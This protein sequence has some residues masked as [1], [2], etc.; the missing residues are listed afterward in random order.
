MAE[1][2][3][4]FITGGGSGIGRAIAQHFSGR[5]WFVG[6]GDVNGAGMAGTAELLPDG[7]CSCHLLDVR[8]AAQWEAALA[9]FAK[10]AGGAIHV[11]ANNAGVGHA[12]AI[13]ELSAA[14]VDALIDVNFRGVVHGARAAHPWL[15]ASAPESCLL[16]LASASAIYGV[17]GMSIYSATKFAVRSITEALDVEW[18]EDGIKV[19]SLMPSFIDTPM[20]QEPASQ[21]SNRTKRDTVVAAGME[22]TPV[23]EVAE[24]AW[25]AVHGEKIHVLVGRTAKTIAFFAR[26]MPSYVRSRSRKVMRIR[27]AR[28]G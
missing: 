27:L 11:V 10:A 13:T 18:H 1:R 15:K 20:L 5:G 16:N 24:A 8:D 26:W 6:L 28:E 3:A 17:G 19:R 23:E 9:D 2:K 12:G 14:Q 22:L 7:A 25:A 21:R 4:I